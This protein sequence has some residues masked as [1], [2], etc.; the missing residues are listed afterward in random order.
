[1][2]ALEL[3]RRNALFSASVDW[4]AV[5]QQA[6][7]ALTHAGRRRLAFPAPR[8]HV[9]HADERADSSNTDTLLATARKWITAPA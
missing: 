3:I 1:M 2:G 5:R 9:R 6:Q 7:D 4:D 8:P